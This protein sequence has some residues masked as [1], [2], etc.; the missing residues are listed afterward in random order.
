MNASRFSALQLSQEATGIRVFTITNPAQFSGGFSDD[1]VT[2]LDDAVREAREAAD[3]LQ[4]VILRF[5]VTDEPAEHIENNSSAESPAEAAARFA[6]FSAALRRL[7]QIGVP[8]VAELTTSVHGAAWEVALAAHYRVATDNGVSVGFPTLL[9]GDVPG[10]G[11]IARTVRTTGVFTALNDV[12][13]SG[14][15]V[16]ADTAQQLGLINDV[17]PTAQV[18]KAVLDALSSA[19][20]SAAMWD[21]KGFRIP[22]GDAR[23]AAIARQLPFF[24]AKVRAKTA[25]EKAMAVRAALAASVEGSCVSL[26]AALVID[27]RYAAN[28]SVNQPNS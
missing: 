20:H 15:A 4:G 5:A 25:P 3:S 26:D 12:I 23:D 8:V 11:G 14:S 17:V 18:K 19:D 7:E 9:D 27:S 13:L 6:H 10:G 16:N 22:G 21:T 28:V 2:A 1:F 24:T